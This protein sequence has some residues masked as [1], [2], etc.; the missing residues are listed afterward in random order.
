MHQERMLR[1]FGF[2]KEEIQAASKRVALARGR[3]RRSTAIMPHN[4]LY[5]WI[6]NRIGAL[7]RQVRRRWRRSRR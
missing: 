7:R 4:R 3:R 5:E 6:D 2:T 1:D